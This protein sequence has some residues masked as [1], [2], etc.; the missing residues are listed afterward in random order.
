MG[1][2]GPTWFLLWLSIFI[3]S[4]AFLQPNKSDSNEKEA[5]KQPNKSITTSTTTTAQ[6]PSSITLNN[7]NSVVISQDTTTSAP[8]TARRTTLEERLSKWF[9]QNFVLDSTLYL[10]ILAVGVIGAIIVFVSGS[11][12]G[13]QML[14]RSPLLGD[15]FPF[16]IVYFFAGCYASTKGWMD[17][18][19]E[20]ET[21]INHDE[22][23]TE[24]LTT[25]DRTQEEQAATSEPSE[26]NVTTNTIHRSRNLIQCA[27]WAAP[28]FLISLIA[29]AIYVLMVEEKDPFATDA[30]TNCSLTDFLVIEC[31]SALLGTVYDYCH[32]VF[33]ASV[34]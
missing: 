5:I 13:I 29:V 10:W 16:W 21:N 34:L 17:V 25:P 32:T 12:K 19:F 15:F 26:P 2:L 11:Y 9:H 33:D 22:D 30:Q 14:D 24:Q 31:C 6:S 8:T 4:Y 20:D 18:L 3:V 23:E 7:N 28:V 27:C 1:G